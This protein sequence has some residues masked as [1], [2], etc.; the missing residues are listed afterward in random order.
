MPQ[1]GYEP[2]PPLAFLLLLHSAPLT[3]PMVCEEGQIPVQSGRMMPP[4]TTDQPQAPSSGATYH[5]TSAD[6]PIGQQEEHPTLFGPLTPLPSL[7][8]SPL[9]D[10]PPVSDPDQGRTASGKCWLCVHTKFV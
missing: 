10:Q 7:P 5:P 9:T 6:L 4:P 8:S 2:K 3:D 1:V